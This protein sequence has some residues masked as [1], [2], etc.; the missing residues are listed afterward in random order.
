MS[1]SCFSI[2]IYYLKKNLKKHVGFS[3]VSLIY[4]IWTFLKMSIFQTSRK[5]FWKIYKK[6]VQTIKVC[7]AFL[8]LFFVRR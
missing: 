4:K 3:K 2:N 7:F 6:V 1:L 8:E 5:L